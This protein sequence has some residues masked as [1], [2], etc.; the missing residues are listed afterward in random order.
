MKKPTVFSSRAF[1][2]GTLSIIFAV[3]IIVAVVLV[4][5][6]ATAVSQ[7]Y[8]F[9]LDLTANKDYTIALTDEYESFV[10]GITMDV[11]L[12][13]CAAADD[14][15]SG[16]YA[17][18]MVQGLGLT[19]YYQ[20]IS[21]TTTKY[22]RQV[23]TF[24]QSFPTKNSKIKL[25]FADP[26]SV[27]EFATVSSRYSSETLNYGDIIL[28]CQHP[29]AEGGSTFE[30]YQI[31]K[32]TDIFST[33]MNQEAYYNGYSYSNTITGSSLASAAVS[34]LY[35]V[36][37]DSSVEVAILGGHNT[38]SEYAG[39]LRTF[40]QK[41]NY[42]FTEVDNLLTASIKDETMFAVL[43]SP[44]SDYTASEIKVLEDFLKNDGKYGRTLVYLPSCGQPELPNLEEFLT[45]WGIEMLPAIS[46]DETEGNYYQYPYWVFAKPAE[47]KYTE[48]MN[49]TEQYFYPMNY[50]LARTAF[51]SNGNY[52]TTKI[53]TTGENTYGYPIGENVDKDWK[54][55]DAKYKGQFDIVTLGTYQHLDSATNVAGES[56]VLMISGDYF[57]YD[58][59]LSTTSCYNSTLLLN[60]FNGLSG[61][62]E[63]NTVSI[64]NKVISNSSFYEKILNTYDGQVM[65]II[66]IGVIPLS[67]IVLSFIIWKTRKRK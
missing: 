64:E 35:I 20:G 51:E 40:L 26:N 5:I 45:E 49:T 39:L 31:L 57:L 54:P 3:I 30:R 47:S 25:T 12:I 28:S 66:F 7:R 15:T 67:M 55:K 9:S 17:S 59:I 1:R 61:Q 19:D 11:E 50:R 16:N 22:A 46:Y 2:K 63:G 13:V 21:D 34:A 32:M 27:T 36:T 14:F 37:S 42:T 60:L 8:P 52:S 43:A 10:S 53:L 33:E 65:M 44:Q 62:E 18:G 58:E 6:A 48:G 24:L 4:N 38:N 56:H 41:N 29:A 23:S